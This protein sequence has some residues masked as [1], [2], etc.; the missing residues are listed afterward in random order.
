MFTLLTLLVLAAASVQVRRAINTAALLLVCLA[1]WTLMWIAVPL[2]SQRRPWRI[3][4]V[5]ALAAVL[6]ACWQV[7]RVAVQIVR[8]LP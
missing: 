7:G 4:G 5:A 2:E 1:V 6:I 3:A 8:H